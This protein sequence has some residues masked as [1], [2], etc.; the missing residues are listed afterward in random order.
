MKT[1]IKQQPSAKYGAN[2]LWIAFDS[3]QRRFVAILSG[4][5]LP[6]NDLMKTTT[7]LTEQLDQYGIKVLPYF[8]RLKIYVDAKSREAEL[9]RLA[10]QQSD[11]H[12]AHRPLPQNEHLVYML[13]LFLPDPEDLQTAIRGDYAITYIEISLDFLTNR[14]RML[15]GISGF[16][17]RHLVHIPSNQSIHHENIKGATDYYSDGKA[18]ECLLTYD[19][20]PSRNGR[21]DHCVHLEMRL[22]KMAMVKK[23]NLITLDNLIKFDFD[24][25]W[26]ALLDLRQPNFTE[27]GKLVSGAQ[28]TRQACHD[29]GKK[30]W[31][32][33]KSVQQYLKAH[34]ERVSA[35]RKMTARALAKYLNEAMTDS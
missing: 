17:K 25:F 15:K 3:A 32:N 26:D 23:H 14:K 18:P 27:L 29:R 19:D 5:Q 7:L 35:F 6:K 9:V 20:Q 11:N 13:D 34:P 24:Q 8:D 33:I 2:R 21:P 12:F 16:M 28:M 31:A 10:K 4:N 1:I 22:K 30:E